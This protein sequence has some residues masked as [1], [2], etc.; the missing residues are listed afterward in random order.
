MPT[1]KRYLFVSYARED[2][3]RVRPLVDA[4]REE[5]T[6]RG[7]PVEPWMDVTELGPGMQWEV[8][9]AEALDSSIGFLF[10]LSPRSLRSNWVQH[11]LEVAA[12]ASGRLIFP[13]LLDEPLDVP[14]SLAEWQWLNLAGQR[15]EEEIA[16][17]AVVIAQATEG[18]LA[19][20]P[21]PRAPVAN[22]EAPSI[23]ADLAQEVRSSQPADVDDR[24]S[25]VFVVHG[26]DVQALGQL[27]EYLTSAGVVP[28][29]L[30]RQGASPQSLFQ[31]FMTIGAKAR[32]AI[33]L[34]GGDDYGASRRQYDAPGVGDR[35][36]Q[37]R[38]RQNVILELGFFYGHL[39]FENVFVVYDEP[40]QVFPNFERPSDLDGVVFDSLSDANWRTRLGERLMAAGFEL[41][42]DR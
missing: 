29:I 17:A 39:G 28:V 36:L 21:S 42:T 19:T 11:E 41:A 38:A 18:Y 33:V 20:T 24:P 4:L 31:K 30:A 35:A 5:L 14:P 26:H 7:L 2:I 6:F 1:D 23:A 34:L 40:D 13:I 12:L 3:D 16:M 8:A 25:S 27:E 9:I 10:F 32:F 22:A 37:Y 15:T